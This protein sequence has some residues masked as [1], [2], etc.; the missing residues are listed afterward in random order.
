MAS[1][2]TAAFTGMNGL[3]LNAVSRFTLNLWFISLNIGIEVH[4]STALSE[5]SAD[6]GKESSNELYWIFFFSKYHQSDIIISTI[7]NTEGI[8][9]CGQAG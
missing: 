9:E 3:R 6:T 8:N 4:N 7:S 2:A 1:S 5:I